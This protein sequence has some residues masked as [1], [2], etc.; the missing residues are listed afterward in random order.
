[1]DQMQDAFNAHLMCSLE[2]TIEEVIAYADTNTHKPVVSCFPDSLLTTIIEQQEY[3]L[4]EP[5]LPLLS[6]E[7]I[8]AKYNHVVDYLDE[9][10]ADFFQDA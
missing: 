5:V 7:D 10:L 9:H 1:M 2:D 8:P 6:L 3:V 4:Q